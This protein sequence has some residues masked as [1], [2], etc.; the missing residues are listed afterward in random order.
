[1][2]RE[3]AQIIEGLRRDHQNMVLLLR[4]LERET[5]RFATGNADFS[6]LFQIMSYLVNYPDLYHHPIESSLFLHLKLRRV[7]MASRVE[8]ILKE[9][10]EIST[11]NRRLAAAIHNCQRGYDQQSEAV[12]G[13]ARRCAALN[14]DHIVSEEK[15]YFPILEQSIDEAGWRLIEEDVARIDDPLFG[16]KVRSEYLSLH[17][18]ITAMLLTGAPVARDEP[19]KLG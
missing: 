10:E 2:R 14:L 18:Q 8:A 6:L 3:S 1:M 19:G 7:D 4:M 15:T 9:H 12:T 13:L 11:L 16:E 5:D 17:R